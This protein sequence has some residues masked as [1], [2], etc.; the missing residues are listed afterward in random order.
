MTYFNATKK[1]GY[2]G[3]LLLAALWACGDSKT[4]E[5]RLEKVAA[6][7]C[8]CSQKLADLDTMT[9]TLSNDTARQAEFTRHLEALQAE[10][11]ATESCLS[12]ILTDYG[13]LTTAQINELER[14]FDQYCPGR[15]PNRDQLIELLAE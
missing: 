15:K 12:L 11:L 2:A 8:S 7:Y 1:I 5:K 14:D 9:A 4:P 6:A 13:R 3:G 10:Y